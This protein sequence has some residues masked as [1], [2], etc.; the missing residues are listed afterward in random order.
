MKLH[1]LFAFQ[2]K[3]VGELGIEGFSGRSKL[4]VIS[5]QRDYATITRVEQRLGRRTEILPVSRDVLENVLH[6]GIG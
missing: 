6:Y 4:A 5:T 1:E 3:D 2:V